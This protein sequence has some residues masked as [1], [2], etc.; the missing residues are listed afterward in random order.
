MG[1]TSRHCLITVGGLVEAVLEAAEYSNADVRFDNTR[2][3]TIPFRMA[4]ITKAANIIGFK[5]SVSLPEG[6]RDTVRW[7]RQAFNA[8]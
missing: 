3:I 7:Y 1:I 8:G 4:D 2:P 6:L 5:P